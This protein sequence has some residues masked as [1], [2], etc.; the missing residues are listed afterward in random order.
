MPAYTGFRDLISLSCSRIFNHCYGETVHSGLEPKTGMLLS[1]SSWRLYHGTAR[2]TLKYDSEN[3]MTS[4]N[5]KEEQKRYKPLPKRHSAC[6][7]FESM[8]YHSFTSQCIVKQIHF[9]L[10]QR[11]SALLCKTLNSLCHPYS[12]A[13]FRVPL[14]QAAEQTMTKHMVSLGWEGNNTRQATSY[15]ASAISPFICKCCCRLLLPCSSQ[16]RCCNCR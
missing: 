2:H 8:F 14:R 13:R 6:N 16:R 5:L 12:R 7:Y 4:C 3:R 15:R 11:L 9:Y 10:T 1:R